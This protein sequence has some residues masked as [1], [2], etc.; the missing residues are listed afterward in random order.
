MPD[1]DCIVSYFNMEKFIYNI[2][3]LNLK[4]LLEEA[5]QGADV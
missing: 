1:R 2:V 5:S 3:W 4:K